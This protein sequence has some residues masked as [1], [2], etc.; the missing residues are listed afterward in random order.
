MQM[1]KIRSEVLILIFGF[2]SACGG[3]KP[4]LSFSA[5]EADQELLFIEDKTKLFIMNS[6]GGDIEEIMSMGR[7]I[8]KP[9]W[10]PNGE[11]IAFF[12]M[13]EK[14]F[15]PFKS[16]M[17]SADLVVLK[18]GGLEPDYLGKFD[19]SQAVDRHG[20]N[21]AQITQPVWHPDGEKIFVH[22]KNGLQLVIPD[23][24]IIPLI[25]NPNMHKLDIALSKAN[26]VY[27]SG[28]ELFVYNF[29][30]RKAVDIAGLRPTL[31]PLFNKKIE[32][33]KFSP[34][35]NS[36][37]IA[38]GKN[39]VLLDLKTLRGR[40]IHRA[41]EAVYDLAWNPNGEQLAILAGKFASYA[42]MGIGGS[43]GGKIP[44]NFSISCVGIDGKKQ[45]L[46]YRN[47]SFSDVRETSV[48]YSAD[49]KWLTFLSATL[50]DPKPHIY[51]AST[52]GQGW[53]ILKAG[54]KY[55]AHNWRPLKAVNSE[56]TK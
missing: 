50:S 30:T 23:N 21:Y 13:E 19:F 26:V 34:D 8:Q 49:G 44:G 22:D 14:D 39:V 2:L 6:R 46:L 17:P 12:L 3:A 24:K 18:L 27:C 47:K 56:K 15:D 4:T 55:S 38:S 36:L 45:H 41:G 53:A 48:A 11:A 25:S 1:K 20:W 40:I 54:S 43:A 9:V 35:E 5:L 29:R 32:A 33:V 16:N 51:I 31:R 7:A 10:A 42:S 37:A 28:N 52:G